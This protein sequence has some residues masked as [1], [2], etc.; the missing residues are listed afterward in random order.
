MPADPRVKDATPRLRTKRRAQRRR[1]L[2]RAGVAVVVLAVIGGLVYLVGFSPVLAAR[3]TRVVGTS[4]LTPEQVTQAAAVPLGTPLARLDTGAV[5][6]RVLALPEARSVDVSRS[7]PGTVVLRVTERQAVYVL[8]S[9]SRFTM[10]DADGTGFHEVPEVTKGMLVA[11]LAA[12]GDQRVRKDVATVVTAL[13]PSIGE[14]AVLVSATSPDQIVI[15]LSGGVQLLWGS[16]EQSAEKA[17]VA[18]A[19]LTQPGKVYDVSS[20][21]HPAVRR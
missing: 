20:P 17:R 11:N 18:A 15:E 4:L 13:P 7:L 12:P 16:A 8:S 2:L 14:R 1:R 10:V 21:S 9:G 6:R 3:A 19:L 5:E